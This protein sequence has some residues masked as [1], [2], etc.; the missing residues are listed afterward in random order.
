MEP[1]TISGCHSVSCIP[2]KKLKFIVRLTD[3]DLPVLFV[4][5]DLV[6]GSGLGEGEPSHHEDDQARDV[7]AVRLSPLVLVPVA[8]AIAG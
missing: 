6:A 2:V 4:V 1:V 3:D 8:V 7:F 5:G